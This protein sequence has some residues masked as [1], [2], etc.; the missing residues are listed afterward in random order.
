MLPDNLSLIF[1]SPVPL[2][3]ANRQKFN[4]AMAFINVPT[5]MP[6]I[7]G[8][9]AFRPETAKPLNEL[10]EVLLQG[11]STLSKGEREL[12]AASM[13]LKRISRPK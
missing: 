7:R 11:P 10:V 1:I 2:V 5:G 9:M 13:Y 6:G 3:R 4:P 8:L 12:I